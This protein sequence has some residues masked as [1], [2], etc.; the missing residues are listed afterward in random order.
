M[1]LIDTAV[2]RPVA[3]LMVFLIIITL[4]LAGYRHLP[5]DLL[6]PIEFPQLT[7]A[8]DYPNVGPEEVEQIIT[9][10]VENA[11]A[12]VPGVE[13]I[14]S[15]S[16]EGGSRVTLDFSRGT[17]LDEAAND[18]RAA[19]DP[20]RDDLPPE[21]EPPRVWKF[22]PNNVPILIVGASSRDR[23]L[24][25][26]TL[27]LEREVARRFEQIPGVGTIDLW[28]GI[29]REVH[30]ELIRDRLNASNLSSA[31]VRAALA[32]G[33]VNLPG[34][35]VATGVQRLYVRTL[36]EF[37][38]LRQIEDTVV[39]T[40]QGRPIRVRDV[41]GVSFGFRDLQ[42]LVKIDGL[43][44]LRIGIRKQSGA[45]TVAVA[46]AIRAEIDRVNR[47]RDDVELFVASDQSTF[48]QASIDNVRQSAMWG[49]L[50]AVVV[51][52]LF[53]RKGSS[54][55]VI[56]VSIPISIIA[57]FGL[58]YF[59]GLTLNQMS[60]GGLA[61]G[62]GLVVDN[63]VVVLENIV[64]HREQ[65]GDGRSSALLGAKQVAGA[66]I[67]STLTTTVVFL[68]V[69]FMQ[70][71][72]GVVFQQLA[73][74]VVFALFCSLLVALTLVPMLASRLAALAERRK[75]KPRLRLAWSRRAMERAEGG[76]ARLLD[77]ALQHRAIVMV[78]AVA[79]VAACVLLI[80]LIPVELAP[81]TDADEIDIDIRMADGTNI[82]VLN[83]Y[84]ARVEELARAHLPHGQVAHLTTDVRHGRAELEISMAPGG[85][86]AT[87]QLADRLRAA[88]VGMIPGAD[89]R[90]DAQSGLWILRRIFGSGGNEDVTV[91]LRGHH[92]EQAQRIAREMQLGI[93]QIPGVEGVRVSSR[94]GRPEENIVF[95]R[96]KLAELGLGVR[97]VAEVLQTNVGGSRAG[98]YRIGGDEYPIVVR[99][100]RE[101]RR[102]SQD[103]DNIPVRLPGGEV[104]PIS[105]V[106]E[107]SAGRGPPEIDRIDGQRVTFIT[108][109]LA[110]G[111]PLGTAVEAIR[112][113]LG[114]V[115][116]PQGFSVYFGGEYEEQQKAAA[117]FRLSLLISVLLIYMVMAAQFERFLD[118][119]IVL[120]SIPLAITGVV[121][122]LLITGTTINM[123]SLMGVVMLG[124]IVVNNAI[125]LVDAMNQIR[126]DEGRDVAV[127]VRQA[128]LR[129]LRPIL[130]TTLTTVLGLLPLSFGIG[131]GAEIQASLARVVLGGLLAS[132]LVTLLF[133]PAL[134][135]SCYERLARWRTGARSEAGGEPETSR[136]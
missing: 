30:V 36:G 58:L 66:I 15:R 57:T 14:R 27:I 99:L 54:T 105:S 128:G 70:T 2:K 115:A 72:S 28:G 24:Q 103:L 86:I 114:S 135:L 10:T 64:R 117:D 74:V 121:P 120:F 43:P 88:T 26:L 91:E 61:L 109:N 7:I 67:A 85:T 124:G 8:V 48:I 60:F 1:S 31:D 95:N 123:Q 79:L 76:Y 55:F 46:A 41:A 110:G 97:E 56:A 65:G 40:Y 87:S 68:P 133:I 25:E 11:V 83:R 52:Y 33:N 19:L 125:L 69:V 111:V 39:S 131:T 78:S 53:L 112:D 29:Y 93:E 35:D 92:L 130:M 47:E 44:M 134:Y 45:N 13:R 71:I 22:D 101:D 108:A 20:I 118:P 51:L 59:S 132:A 16:Q 89:I 4:G 136:A 17:N 90:V 126:R 106:I 80:P 42:R 23:D 38:S 127:A 62:V 116:I 96:P 75:R 34:G 100:R 73:L 77:V 5:I 98:S 82:A 18:L 63:A 6:P 32:R 129:R 3:T 104:I 113:R 50:L 9:Q 94:E 107:K 119:L 37:A 21:A 49:A 12:G 84:L 81:Q 122:T 102:S